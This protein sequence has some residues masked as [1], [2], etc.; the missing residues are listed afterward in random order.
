MFTIT[1]CA[2]DKAPI[3]RTYDAPVLLSDVLE[4]VHAPHDMPCGG[5]GTCGKCRVTAQGTLS[6]PSDAELTHLSEA[7]LASGIR[8]SCQTYATGDATVYYTTNADTVQ[9]ISTGF[10]PDFPLHPSTTTDTCLGVAVDIGTTTIAAYLYAFPAGKCIKT[11]CEQNA[12]ARYGAD[13]ISRIEYA[14]AGGLSKLQEAITEQ[15]ARMIGM[16]TLEQP[17]TVVITG[18]TTMLHLYAGLPVDGIAK[19]PFTPTSYFGQWQGRTYLPRCIS[20]YVGADITTAILA[21]DMKKDT[22]SFLVDIGTNGEM[23]LWHNGGLLCCSTAAGPAFEG[24][25]ITHGML[26]ADGAINKVYIKDGAIAYETIGGVP[27]K[28]ICGTGLIDAI[29]C[30]LDLGVLDETGYL[31]ED[32]QIGDSGIYITTQDVRAVQL[33]KAAISAGIE[34]LLHKGGVSVSQLD[35]FYIAGGFGSMIDQKSAA[36]IG[37]IPTEALPKVKVLGNAAGNG[38]AMLLLSQE[39]LAESEQVGKEAEAIELSGDDYFRD[40]YIEKMMFE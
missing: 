19:A 17:D 1:V 8:L 40:C 26:A 24:A 38:A 11:V 3:S 12:Q 35:A 16:L 9:A 5:R 22:T 31:E 39:K 27:A 7:D 20:A 37:L 10:M 14:T 21:S 30:M 23:A 28:G 33:A 18:N 29:G 34:T 36:R 15:I 6:E 13:V 32:Y 2:P 25:G 4:A